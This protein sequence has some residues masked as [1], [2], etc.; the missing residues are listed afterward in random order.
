LDATG[1]F[2]G[3]SSSE[4]LLL[5]DGA[6][7]LLGCCTGVDVD[8]GLV[9]ATVTFFFL[10]SSLDESESDDESFFLIV[11]GLVTTGVTGATQKKERI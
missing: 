2:A 11:A 9:D 3:V 10:S 5:L 6:A 8:N 1:F 7:R 4:S